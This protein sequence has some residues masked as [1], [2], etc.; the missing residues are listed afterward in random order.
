MVWPAF[1]F[2]QCTQDCRSPGTAICCTG[3][4]PAYC[5]QY[6]DR[7][8]AKVPFEAHLIATDDITST[9][10]P[11]EVGDTR[12]AMSSARSKQFEVPACFPWRREPSTD[13][14]ALSDALLDTFMHTMQRGAEMRVLLDD[15]KLLEVEASLDAGLTRLSLGVKEVTRD[16][17]LTDIERVSGPDEAQESCTTNSEHLSECCTTLVLSSTHFLTF[18]FETKRQREYFESC[19]RSVLMSQRAAVSNYE[20]DH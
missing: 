4:A 11:S 15:G 1:L 7:Q 3:P 17:F 2:E 18:S 12:S 6:A 10:E 16:I 13:V 9:A 20:S 19:M 14:Q 8:K 5:S